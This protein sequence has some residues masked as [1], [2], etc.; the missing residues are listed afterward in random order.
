MWFRRKL[1]ISKELI[2]KYRADLLKGLGEGPESEKTLYISHLKGLAQLEGLFAQEPKLEDLAAVLRTE[3]HRHGWSFLSGDVGEQATTSA[4]QLYCYLE[5]QIF[6]MK[7]KD[8]YYS[9]EHPR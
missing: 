2:E 8:W 4:D 3:R 6:R 7:G 1:N 9:N 5:Q